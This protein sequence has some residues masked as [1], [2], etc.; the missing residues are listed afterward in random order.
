MPATVR[1]KVPGASVTASET[2]SRAVPWLDVRSRSLSC[3]GE[4]VARGFPA[5]AASPLPT[6]M[7]LSTIQIVPSSIWVEQSAARGSYQ[8]QDAF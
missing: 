5:H 1:T 3:L 7:V 2:A 6:G 8:P 4:P